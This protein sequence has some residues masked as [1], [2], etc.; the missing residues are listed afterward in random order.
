MEI[1]ML[2]KRLIRSCRAGK[3]FLEMSILE[4]RK[5]RKKAEIDV[6]RSAKLCSLYTPGGGGVSL[7]EYHNNT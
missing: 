4:W 6:T 2:L 3:E 1:E 7:A 5:V